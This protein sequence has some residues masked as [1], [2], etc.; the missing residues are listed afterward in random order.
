MT[1]YKSLRTVRDL[2]LLNNDGHDA[3]HRHIEWLRSTAKKKKA[4]HHSLRGFIGI[5][6]ELLGWLP[7][8]MWAKKYPTLR[9]YSPQK[10]IQKSDEILAHFPV[11]YPCISQ[12]GNFI[13]MTRKLSITN[14]PLLLF[15]HPNSDLMNHDFA[16]ISVCQGL[17]KLISLIGCRL[18]SIGSYLIFFMGCI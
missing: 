10:H 11:L 15:S 13:S 6:S 8:Q 5:W 4:Y 2:P 18:H 14:S 9:S 1:S 12:P 16:G 3:E 7:R 17:S